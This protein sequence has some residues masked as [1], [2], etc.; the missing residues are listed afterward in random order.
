MLVVLPIAITLSACCGIR[1]RREA[2]APPTPSDL[3]CIKKERFNERLRAGLANDLDALFELRM[4]FLG[5]ESDEETGL[6]FM[7]RAAMLGDAEAQQELIDIY[8]SRP[9]YRARLEE[10]QSKWPQVNR[11]KD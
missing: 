11:G 4:H 3:T 5:C 7:E 10:L 9:Q 6:A 8:G 2:E 1:E